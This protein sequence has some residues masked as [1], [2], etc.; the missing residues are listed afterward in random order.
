M[1]IL[2]D[3]STSCIVMPVRFCTFSIIDLSNELLNNVS[4]SYKNVPV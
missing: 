3:D 4:A 1:P 2:G